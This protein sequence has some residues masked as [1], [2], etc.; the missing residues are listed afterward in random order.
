MSLF[1]R[2][3]N[4][5]KCQMV[6]QKKELNFFDS[7]IRGDRF[8]GEKLHLCQNCFIEMVSEYFKNYRNKAVVVYPIKKYNAYQFYSMK[9]LKKWNFSEKFIENVKQLLSSMSSECDECK[10]K[11]NFIWCSPE[12]YNDDPFSGKIDI[13]KPFEKRFLCGNCLSEEFAK[14]ICE[15]NLHFDEF[16]PPIDFDGFCTS[17]EV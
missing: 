16:F 3:S 1:K 2:E 15:N 10:R 13:S 7:T 5:E 11:A 17:F 8:G 14:K 9:D 6:F 12:I 4:C